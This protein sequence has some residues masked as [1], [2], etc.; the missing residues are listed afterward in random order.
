MPRV[1]QSQEILNATVMVQGIGAYS[2]K[3][4][5]RKI[6]DTFAASLQ[7]EINTC[8][9][10]NNEQEKLKARLKDKTAECEA[11]FV[12]LRLRTAEARKIIKL[13]MPQ[14]LWREFGIDDKR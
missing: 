7:Q 9:T 1:T 10:L 11:A 4:A 3:L 6:D 8:V 13:D 2:E 5:Q 14:T 12:A